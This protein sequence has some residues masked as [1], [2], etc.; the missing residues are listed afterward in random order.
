MNKLI[1]KVAGVFGLVMAAGCVGA[2]EETSQSA[3]AINGGNFAASWQW[4]RSAS[5]GYCAAR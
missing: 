4:Q 5:F 2:P 1:L 3:S